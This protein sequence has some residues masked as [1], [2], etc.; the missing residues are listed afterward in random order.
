MATR[1][2]RG[3]RCGHRPRARTRRRPA[4]LS[5]ARGGAGSAGG[6][7]QHARSFRRGDRGDRGGAARR[8]ATR[9]RRN[10]RAPVGAARHVPHRARRRRGVRRPGRGD[11]PRHRG[12]GVHAAAHGAE[13]PCD[14]GGLA[15]P[16]RRGPPDP[17]GA[18]G[19]PRQRS[20]H[21]YAPVGRRARGGD[22][23]HARGL[24]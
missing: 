16:A 2:R 10:A 9:A 14:E 15:R 12:P 4:R 17:S 3:A 5:G 24:G 22:E 21:R 7:P 1:R 6:R 23:L 8:G 11:L 18:A 19:E 13:Q 20:Q